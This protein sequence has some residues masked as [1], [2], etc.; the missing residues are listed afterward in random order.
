MDAV[1]PLGLPSSLVESGSSRRV[2]LG[3]IFLS[4]ERAK[5]WERYWN[6]I[7]IKVKSYP[8]EAFL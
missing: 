3:G 5:S 1:S 8:L 2:C 4:S 6:G 7:Y